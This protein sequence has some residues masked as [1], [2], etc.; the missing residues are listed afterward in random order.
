MANRPLSRQ[1]SL[2]IEDAVWDHLVDHTRQRGE[3]AS[4][5]VNLVLTDALGMLPTSAKAA[6]TPG[7]ISASAFK[8]PTSSTTTFDPAL[9]TMQPQTTQMEHSAAAPTHRPAAET[10]EHRMTA[11]QGRDQLLNAMSTKPGKRK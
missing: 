4:Q 10:P 7:D 1:H 2:Y 5:F 6:Y 11:Q 3:S 8:A 9:G